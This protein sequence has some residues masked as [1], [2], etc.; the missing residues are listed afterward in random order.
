MSE[1]KINMEYFKMYADD[2]GKEVSIRYCE[3]CLVEYS[4][5]LSVNSSSIRMSKEQLLW[6]MDKAQEI[7]DFAAK[8]G[9]END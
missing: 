6:F 3:D 2:S 7:L 4:F 5:N 9:G 1:L 8:T